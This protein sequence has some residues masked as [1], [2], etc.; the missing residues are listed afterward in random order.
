MAA[1]RRA[2]GGGGGPVTLFV[3]MRNTPPV[4]LLG[5]LLCAPAAA[6]GEIR[7]E[8]KPA[9]KPDSTGKAA[10]AAPAPKGPAADNSRCFVCHANYD[11]NEEK[12]AFTHA[13]A[14]IGCVKCH[15]ES[16][17]HSTDEDGLTAPDRMYPTAHIRFN[18]LGCH[19]W[20]KLI[21][22]DRTKQ[23]RI[24]LKEKP[25]HQ[26]VLN[27]TLKDKKICTDCHG[28]HRLGHRTRKWD[29][30]TSELIYRD[31]TPQMLPGSPSS[32]PGA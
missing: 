18:C 30:R 26:A 3:G 22:S 28:E 29:K 16:S 20:V 31:G 2:S 24:D 8:G 1:C 19:D 4:L 7:P 12:L 25:D 21:V 10:V 15:G 5:L 9:E 32:K 17:R 13:Q 11:F 6:D 27:G 23:T 14:N